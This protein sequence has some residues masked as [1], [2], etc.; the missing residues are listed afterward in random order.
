[1]GAAAVVL[2][3]ACASPPPAADP[4]GWHPVLLPGKAATVY[5]RADKDG[6]PALR[7]VSERSASMWRRRVDLPPER[8]GEVSFSW[9]VPQALE[10]ASVA[11]VD[12][13]DAAVRVIF[14]FGGDHAR[15]PLRTRAM[16][17]LAEALTGERPP[18]ATLM[19]VWDAHLPV[20]SV[21]VNPRSDRIRKIVVDSGAGPL[22]QW[23]DHRRN[24]ADDFRRA[25]GEEPGPL[26]SIAIMTDSDNTRSRARSWYG[27]VTL[28]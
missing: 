4:E 27:P 22:R 17:D 11:D 12:R 3:G 25:F 20:G 28:H 14:A 2:L 9:W 8:L 7:A 19:Y 26:V 21:V 18:Y 16:F 23:R 10:H 1:M 24:L 13:E 6:R 15:L 5:T